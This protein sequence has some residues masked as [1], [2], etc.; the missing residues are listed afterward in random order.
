[1]PCSA[2]NGEVRLWD[3]STKR[4]VH[5]WSA[6]HAKGLLKAGYFENE[7]IIT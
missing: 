4:A 7:T 5:Q 1:M 3:L 6:V 2:A